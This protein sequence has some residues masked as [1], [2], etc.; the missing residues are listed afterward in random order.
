MYRA[1]FAVSDDVLWLGAQLDHGESKHQRG[2][3]HLNLSTH[4][5]PLSLEKYESGL[6]WGQ[7]GIGG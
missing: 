2:T 1:S 6:A 3:L 4:C 5:S 7:G